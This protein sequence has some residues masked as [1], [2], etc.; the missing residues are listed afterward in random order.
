MTFESLVTDH[1]ISTSAEALNFIYP[2]TCELLSYKSQ[3]F[4][5][6]CDGGFFFFDSSDVEVAAAA[7]SSASSTFVCPSRG[8]QAAFAESARRTAAAAPA[9]AAGATGKAFGARW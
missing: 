9:E 3:F 4:F 6:F 8:A 1:P 2:L 5:G 7:W